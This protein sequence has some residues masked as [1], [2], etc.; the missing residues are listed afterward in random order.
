MT[1]KQ[2]KETE[3]ET[4]RVAL[5]HHWFVYFRRKEKVICP[6]THLAEV[7]ENAMLYFFLTISKKW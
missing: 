4:R 1:G 5:H 6:N 2:R 3:Q 7:R